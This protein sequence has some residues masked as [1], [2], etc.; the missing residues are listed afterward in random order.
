[1]NSQ[2]GQETLELFMIQLFC[3]QMQ[4]ASWWTK[5][6]AIPSTCMC[7]LTKWQSTVLVSFLRIIFKKKTR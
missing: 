4:L 1:M 6:G 5:S 7:S 2:L 3:K